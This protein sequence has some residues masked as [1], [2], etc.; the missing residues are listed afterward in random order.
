MSSNGNL[1]FTL[2]GT[3][4]PPKHKYFVTTKWYLGHMPQNCRLAQISTHIKPA[5][6]ITQPFKSLD[7]WKSVSRQAGSLNSPWD[8]R[9]QPWWVLLRG[10][11]KE[12]AA[13]PH[14]QGCWRRAS[15]VLLYLLCCLLGVHLHC[16][17]IPGPG[18]LT[19]WYPADKGHTKANPTTC[20]HSIP[21]G[22][23][24]QEEKQ[25]EGPQICF[26][27]HFTNSC[28]VFLETLAIISVPVVSPGKGRV[29]SL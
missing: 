9:H 13:G 2:E 7:F 15:S 8:V 4:Y 20:H 27:E 28:Y 3:C 25:L 29:L 21:L 19:F 16:C 1:F 12:Q 14:P 6:G 10:G 5:V 26:Y 24:T 17:W 22:S 18:F 23:F 11:C